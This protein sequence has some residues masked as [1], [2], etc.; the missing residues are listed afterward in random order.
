[1]TTLT[2]PTSI[3]PHTVDWHLEANTGSFVSPLTRAVQTT[4]LAGARWV[5]EFTLPT[6]TRD[7]WRAWSAFA[8]RMRGQ[9]GRVYVRPFHA[10]GSSAPTFAAGLDITCD[11]TSKKCDSSTPTMDARYPVSLGTPLINGASQTGASIVTDGWA[12]SAMIFEQ[13]DFFSY[14]TTAG[15]TLHM[16]VA[17]TESDRTG[18]ATLTVEPPIRTSPANNAALNIATPTCV[19][20]L[21]DDSVG[22]LSVAPGY[23]GSVNISLIESF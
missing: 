3:T 14:D 13:G 22:A 11:S 17:Y 16:V 2:W 4:E 20:R 23:F 8:A 6:M 1:M 12:P 21:K 5:A 10:T 15:R 9:A 19:M 18:A 7:T